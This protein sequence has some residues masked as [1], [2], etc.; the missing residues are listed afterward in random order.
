LHRHRT[1]G[2]VTRAELRCTQCGEPMHIDTID[3]L[4]GPGA[5]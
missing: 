3:V 2:A 4:P 1:C 5:A